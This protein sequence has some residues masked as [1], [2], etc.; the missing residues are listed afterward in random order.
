TGRAEPHP[1]TRIAQERGDAVSD[2][3]DVVT[4]YDEARVAVYDGLTHAPDVRRD[5]R[6]P[7]AHRLE[8]AP[9]EPLP[10]A[11]EGEELTLRE[12]PGPEQPHAMADAQVCR[13]R[14]GLRA[15]R[16]VADHIQ[17]PRHRL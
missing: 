8:D 14:R 12:P 13:Q 2:R 15:Q 10:V 17:F 9:R 5:D 6:Q 3:R 16:A 4:R 11:D 1:Q 7:R